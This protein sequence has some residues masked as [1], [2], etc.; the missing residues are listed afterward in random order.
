[1]KARSRILASS[2]PCDAMHSSV[3]NSTS[4]RET[5][6]KHD[7]C[8]RHGPLPWPDC[9]DAWPLTSL[10]STHP[11]CMHTQHAH[12]ACTHSMHTHTVDHSGDTAVSIASAATPNATAA[13][14]S[15][16]LA[17]QARCVHLWCFTLEQLAP[18]R[19]RA[20]VLCGLAPLA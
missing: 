9:D 4:A 12:T 8:L 5:R 15:G 3:S 19:G 2:M 14:Y 7:G 18:C 20:W 6:K 1:M 17:K 10:S 11:V 16:K 13:T